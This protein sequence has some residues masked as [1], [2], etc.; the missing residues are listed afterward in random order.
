MRI[1]GDERNGAVRQPWAG[2]AAAGMLIMILTASQAN[3]ASLGFVGEGTSTASTAM[4][5]I[6]GSCWQATTSFPAGYLNVFV[7]Q[8]TSVRMAGAVYTAANLTSPQSLIGTTGIVTAHQGWNHLVFS[9]PV[10]ITS[11]NFYFIGFI[12]EGANVNTGL[13]PVTSHYWMNNQ[14]DIS[15][16]TWPTPPNP[17]NPMGSVALSSP[18]Q[19][20]ACY[21]TDSPAVP[22]QVPTG[23][24]TRTFTSTRTASPSSTFSPT[25]SISATISPT[26]SVSPT[27]PGS[28]TITPTIT[29][30][31]AATLSPTGTFSRTFTP[32]LTLTETRT[33]V[34]PGATPTLT[35]Y[36]PGHSEVMVFPSP[37]HGTGG[38]FYF[39]AEGGSRVEAV[40]YN[41]AGEEI[42][43]EQF[44]IQASGYQRL[45]WAMGGLAP[46]VYFYRLAVNQGGKRTDFGL[47]KMVVV[48]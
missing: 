48:P 12:F 32:T 15:F 44:S 4:N 34:L 2:Y 7:K 42:H 26:F 45:P 30:S 18:N 33:P 13:E 22:T 38:W 39:W 31:P 8:A 9:T 23:T 43:R 6:T 35:P 41:L 1:P 47:K 10:T 5:W 20:V 19:A 21:I 40:F 36:L 46:G 3:A 24:S 11:G 28:G 37:L 14:V 17:P 27:N 16:S 29:N 25:A